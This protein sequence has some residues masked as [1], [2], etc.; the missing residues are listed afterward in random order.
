MNPVGFRA[1]LGLASC[2]FSFGKYVMIGKIA[3]QHPRISVTLDLLRISAPAQAP[4]IS[5]QGCIAGSG[6]LVADHSILT[7]ALLNFFCLYLSN[8]NHSML[9]KMSVLQQLA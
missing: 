1:F 4:P 7:K 6:C 8:R 2:L 5:L 3:P 9:L